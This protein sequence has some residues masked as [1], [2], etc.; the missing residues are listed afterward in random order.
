MYWIA[1]ALEKDF[2][3]TKALVFWEKMICECPHLRDDCQSLFNNWYVDFL[4][5]CV[6]VQLRDPSEG[7][8]PKV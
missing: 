2:G 4:I 8:S 7:S 5:I 6:E 1:K 3:Y